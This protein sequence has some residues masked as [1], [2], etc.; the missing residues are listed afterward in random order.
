M[1]GEVIFV[2]STV[3]ENEMKVH[4]GNKLV[5]RFFIPGLAT[6]SFGWEG[7]KKRGKHQPALLL[8]HPELLFKS[9]EN[10][11][12]LCH[13]NRAA[14]FLTGSAKSSQRERALRQM[15]PACT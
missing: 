15:M 1:S 12:K 14:F 11:T 8:A 2:F 13:T 10:L 7:E 9:T 6:L 5:L 4:N 3:Q